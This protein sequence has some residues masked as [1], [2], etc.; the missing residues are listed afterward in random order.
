MLTA[1]RD[2]FAPGSGWSLLVQRNTVDVAHRTLRAVRARWETPYVLRCRQ[3]VGR[4]LSDPIA[5]IA[6]LLGGL[7]FITLLL[8]AFEQWLHA[9]LPNP[10]TVNLPLIG[11]LAYY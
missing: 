10:G 4:W 9:P 11:M 5:G 1:P 3:R 2:M 7:V 8:V 6:I